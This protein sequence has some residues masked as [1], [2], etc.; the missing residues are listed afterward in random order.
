MYQ[1][2]IIEDN[3]L[4]LNY[5]SFTFGTFGAFG[6][7]KSTYIKGGRQSQSRMR[8]TRRL[9]SCV[10]AAKPTRARSLAISTLKADFQLSLRRRLDQ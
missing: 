8:L 4:D 5:H 3:E 1:V 6:S 7:C 10:A 2:C 9:Q